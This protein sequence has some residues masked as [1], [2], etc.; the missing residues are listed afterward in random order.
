VENREYNCNSFSTKDKHY[1]VSLE[2]GCPC[3]DKFFFCSHYV[4]VELFAIQAGLLV[5]EN[6]YVFRAIQNFP[7]G[8]TG[9]YKISAKKFCYRITKTSRIR[10]FV[11]ICPNSN[12]FIN[13]FFIFHTFILQKITKIQV[14]AKKNY[15]NSG[16][17]RK[18]QNRE[19]IQIN[20]KKFNNDN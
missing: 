16:K 1:R 19:K 17:M 18:T 12:N 13:N 4:L 5:L 20:L 11:V 9:I 10:F 7:T 14:S 3:D 6:R 8:K 2:N 15:T